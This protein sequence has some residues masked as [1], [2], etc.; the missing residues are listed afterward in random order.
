MDTIGDFLTRIRNAAM[1]R[2]EKVDV[3]NSLVRKGIAEILKNRG[4]IR[5]FRIVKDGRQG[6]M[7]LYLK[8]NQKGEPVLKALHRKSRPGRREYVS[9]DRIPKVRN[10]FGMAIL[11]TNRGILSG[12][13]A[14]SQRVGGELLCNVW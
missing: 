2:H 9:V 11:S 13:E 12:E 8:Y 10:G 14:L 1:A 3:P 4:Y 6:I 5:D 7:R